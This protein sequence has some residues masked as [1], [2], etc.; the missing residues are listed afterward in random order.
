MNHQGCLQKQF[1]IQKEARR[2]NVN[3]RNKT[4]WLKRRWYVSYLKIFIFFTD[5]ILVRPCLR[6]EL[7]LPPVGWWKSNSWSLCVEQSNGWA[8][9]RVEITENEHST[10]QN[11]WC[12]PS[13][14]SKKMYKLVTNM[15]QS[16]NSAPAVRLKETCQG[17]KSGRGWDA[18]ERKPNW[19]YS[20][21]QNCSLENKNLFQLFK[22]QSSK[23]RLV[24]RIWLTLLT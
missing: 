12:C 21:I 1:L 20:S 17:G 23:G 2:Y 9:S 14:L 19:R 4:L 18:E 11:R 15:G 7:T 16:G 24:L 10:N 22:S 6:Q 13:I 5:M 8:R 3:K